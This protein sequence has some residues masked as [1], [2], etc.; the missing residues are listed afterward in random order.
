MFTVMLLC[1]SCSSPIAHGAM[2]S[3]CC[4]AIARQGRLEDWDAIP[5]SERG[6]TQREM[7]D[8]VIRTMA[9]MERLSNQQ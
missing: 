9:M 8:A 6:D 2:C 7:T 3:V 1:V 5:A 4:E